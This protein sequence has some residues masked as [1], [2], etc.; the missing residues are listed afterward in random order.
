MPDCVVAAG[1]SAG[2]ASG[3]DGGGEFGGEDGGGRGGEGV[4][5]SDEAD[6]MRGVWGGEEGV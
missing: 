3:A 1:E 5:V 6:G 2:S 4:G